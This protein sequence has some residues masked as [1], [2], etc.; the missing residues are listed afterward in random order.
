MGFFKPHLSLRQS[1]T[2]TYLLIINTAFV[3]LG[4]FFV[5]DLYY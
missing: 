5:G 2:S 3:G 4:I 1:A